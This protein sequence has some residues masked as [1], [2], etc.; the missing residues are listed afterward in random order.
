VAGAPAQ[1]P[2]T[3]PRGTPTAVPGTAWPPRPVTLR[4]AAPKARPRPEDPRPR[5]L[6]VVPPGGAV[7]PK[8]AAVSS[9]GA[10]SSAISVESPVITW[11]LGGGA[12]GVMIYGIGFSS[13]GSPWPAA[14]VSGEGGARAFV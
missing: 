10:E 14:R 5:P 8:R 4:P 3:D 11:G 9:A 1:S 7:A 13:E 12:P 2:A 6:P